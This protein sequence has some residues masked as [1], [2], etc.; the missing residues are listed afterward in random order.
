A[1]AIWAFV[2]RDIGGAVFRGPRAGG[3][4]TR[5]R[6]AA[7]P[8][9]RVPVLAQ[10]DQQ[11]GWI[12]GWAIAMAILAY[13]LASLARTI[14]DGFKDVPAMQVYLQRAGIGGYAD[15]VGVVWFSTALLLIAIFVVAQVNAWAADD[16]E[17]RLEAALA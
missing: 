10:V 5:W 13:F 6:P 9:L 14:V 4:A 16:G 11:R 2:R 3:H 15:V 8:L 17:G 7:D 1:L 12:A